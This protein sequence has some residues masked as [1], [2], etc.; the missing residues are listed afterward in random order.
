[1]KKTV[2][3]I[4]A[5]VLLLALAALLLGSAGSSSDPLISR[6]WL[7]GDYRT[8]IVRELDEHITK[9]FNGVYS[10]ITSG[11]PLV[12]AESDYTHTSGYSAVNLYPGQTLLLSQGTSFT[13]KSGSV[14]VNVTSGV[15]LDLTTAAEAKNQITPVT[16]RCYLL[17]EDSACA[18][19][20]GDRVTSVY[21]DGFYKVDGTAQTH[22]AVF[23]DVKLDAWYYK[24][25]DYAYSNGL[26]SGTSATEF[27]P[28]VAM[29]RGMFV[30]VLYRLSGTTSFDATS[31][32]G[33]PDVTNTSEYYYTPVMW[34]AENGIVLGGSDG[35]F[36]PNTSVTR[37]QMATIMFRYA[38]WIGRN[39]AT[40][41]NAIAGFPDAGSVSDYATDAMNWAV[42]NAIINGSDGKLLPLDTA[43]RAHV[44]QII[45]NF[46]TK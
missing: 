3:N 4:I 35:Y 25:V 5:A 8:A 39:T 17:P 24:A 44:A 2:K 22:H 38:S 31:E 46:A 41:T 27:S 28:D 42:T 33:F 32:A 15:V 40:T 34:A 20:T 36:Y 18:V 21:I 29:T 30:T 14:A 16:G 11:K 43:Q 13:V 10:S 7:E 6:I 45:M 26:F 23:K 1:M 19:T 12:P 37:E 9:G